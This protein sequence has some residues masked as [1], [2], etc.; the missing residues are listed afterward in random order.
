[1][2]EIYYFAG[3]LEVSRLVFEEIRTP[4]QLRFYS[5]LFLA[6]ISSRKADT[7]KAQSLLREVEVFFP[8]GLVLRQRALLQASAYFG[9]GQDRE[10]YRH[11]TALVEDPQYQRNRHLILKYIALDPNFDGPRD[12]TKLNRLLASR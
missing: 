2:G 7:D 12:E 11:L 5:A 6:M 4:L 1:M 8:E 10:G 9:L 3:D